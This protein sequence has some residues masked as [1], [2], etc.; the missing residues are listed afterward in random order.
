MFRLAAKFF[1]ILFTGSAFFLFWW[2]G[3]LLSWTALPIIR[4]RH[5]RDP[6][7][8]SRRCRS[9]LNRSLRFHADYMR[10]FGL[11]D[12]DS[13]GLEKKLPQGPFVL[14]ANHPSLVD[15]VLLLSACPKMFCVVKGPVMHSPFV[16]RMM[17]Y[18]DHIDAGDGGP[19]SGMAVLQGAV[20]RL[21]AGDPVLIF[22]EGT[23]SPRNALGPFHK[24]AF[25]I[26]RLAGVPVV[27]LHIAMS[28][29]GLMR[30]MKWYTVPDD[31]MRYKFKVLPPCPPERW[32][33]DSGAM[34]KAVRAMIAS[35]FPEQQPDPAAAPSPLPSRDHVAEPNERRI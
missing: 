10:F 26:A 31:T 32:S 28:P 21:R 30:G 9:L 8:G 11:I 23:R 6:Q 20:D 1:R 33:G 2:G 29:P 22:P 24:G 7:E 17:R 16:G 19:A 27:P 34:S 13:R 14:V 15:V 5:R 18:A 3:L 35:E 25:A 4:F 12:F